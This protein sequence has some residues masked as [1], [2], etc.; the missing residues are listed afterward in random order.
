VEYHLVPGVLAREAGRSIGSGK[1]ALEQEGTQRLAGVIPM[2]GVRPIVTALRGDDVGPGLR[3]P[4]TDGNFDSLRP[5][6]TI[7]A[8]GFYGTGRLVLVTGSKR[9]CGNRREEIK[10]LFHRAVF[11]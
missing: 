1:G 5:L 8:F 7:R 4:A 6:R 3:D 10:I 9:K 2:G 11:F